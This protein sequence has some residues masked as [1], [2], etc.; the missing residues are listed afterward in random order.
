[1]SDQ[2]VIFD[3]DDTLQDFTKYYDGVFEMLEHQSASRD[4]VIATFADEIVEQEISAIQKYI[5]GFYPRQIVARGYE[6]SEDDAGKLVKTEELIANVEHN[7]KPKRY[8]NPFVNR[9]FT[10]DLY[11]VKRLHAQKQKVEL[12]NAI[13]VADDGDVHSSYSDPFVP[14]IYL[15][16]GNWV[17]R[18]K[19]ETVMDKLFEGIPYKVFDE[20]YSTGRKLPDRV[21]DGRRG[22]HLSK[23]VEVN[24]AHFHIRLARAVDGQEVRVIEE[25]VK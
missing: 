18:K 3:L 5:K 1:M 13:F 16:D 19:I 4:C 14:C 22:F 12:Q 15:E 10:K 6:Y 23:I 24:V 8:E 21:N 17:K 2:L 20:L 9:R 7:V 25:A 11:L